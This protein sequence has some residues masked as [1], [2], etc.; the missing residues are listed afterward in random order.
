M[1]TA[2]ENYLES[3]SVSL[4]AGVYEPFAHA[5]T[6]VKVKTRIHARTLPDNFFFLANL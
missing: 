3:V 2:I 5:V 6:T 4:A 1:Y